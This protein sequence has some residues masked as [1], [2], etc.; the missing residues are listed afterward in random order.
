MGASRYLTTEN[1]RSEKLIKIAILLA[2]GGNLHQTTAN[3]KV[4]LVDLRRTK[5]WCVVAVV[6]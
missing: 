1:R 6:Q 2:N 3:L 5:K 4:E